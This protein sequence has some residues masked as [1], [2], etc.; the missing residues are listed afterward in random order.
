GGGVGRGGAAR[1]GGRVA[2]QPYP[3]LEVFARRAALPA[4]ALEALAMAGA[5]GCFGVPRREALWAAGAAATIRAGQL[6]GTTVGLNAPPLP[7]MTAAQETFADL[8][9]TRT[10][11]THPLAHVRQR[12][13]DD[14]GIPA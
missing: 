11:G 13:T 4:R 10:Y 3:G 12:L 2:G 1:A 14:G 5:F 7:A 6:P 8:W 9:A